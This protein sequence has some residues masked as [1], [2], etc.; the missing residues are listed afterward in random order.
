MA[1][2]K[3][4]SWDELE[5]MEDVFSRTVLCPNLSKITGQE[6][7]VK[8]K[9]ITP[10]DFLSAINFPMDEINQMVADN[11]GEE[12][13]VKAIQEQTQALGVDGLLETM[14]SIVKLGLVDPDPTSGSLVKLSADFESIFK[15]IVEMSLPGEGVAK[16][17]K[18]PSDGEQ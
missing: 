8:I 4:V 2:K 18:F 11:A 14:E 7:Y 3:I 5:G 9:A 10:V 6:I 13:F 1:D 15:E 16:A 12:V 17:S